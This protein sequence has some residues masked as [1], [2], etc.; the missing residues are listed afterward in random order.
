M[1]VLLNRHLLMQTDSDSGALTVHGAVVHRFAEPGSLAGTVYRGRDAVGRFTLHVDPACETKQLN[2]DLV[3]IDRSVGLRHAAEHFAVAAG[4]HVVFWVSKGAGGYAVV[5]AAREP[6]AK[7]SF[8][9]R[10][11]GA[12]DY[13]TVNPLRPGLYG[14]T[15]S[16]SK[17]EGRLVVAYPD[18]QRRS[19]TAAAPAAIRAGAKGFSPERAEIQP[20]QGIVFQIEAPSRIRIALLEPTDRPRAKGEQPEKPR[21]AKKAPSKG[22]RKRKSAK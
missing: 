21:P 1:K 3:Q 15:N 16:Q 13:F 4:G 20:M 10:T 22:A 9:S 12:G 2:L 8:D 11:L 7:P 14:A 5:L 19:R 18:M 17:A 6:D